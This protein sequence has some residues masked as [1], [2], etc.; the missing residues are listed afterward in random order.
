[1]KDG[2]KDSKM[3][4]A[5]DAF[6]S[7]ANASWTKILKIYFVS[8]FFLAT[9]VAF[10]FAYTA[11]RDNE[12]VRS[13]A[14]KLS[15]ERQVE[16]LR[17]M[18]VTPK[19]QEELYELVHL[20]NADRAFVF[21]LHNGKKNTSGLPFRYADM[22]YEEVNDAK[23]GFRVAMNFQDIPL[24]LYKYPHYLQRQKLFIGTVD[25]IST[26]DPEFANHIRDIGGEYLAMI[27]MSSKGLP[28]GFLCVS[29]HNRESVPSDSMIENKLREYDRLI[30]N[31]LDLSTYK[32]GE[33]TEVS[34]YGKDN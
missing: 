21:E 9:G 24:T 7:I 30:S 26:I 22:T 14:E 32:D 23:K 18:V 6:Q 29:Y 17:D 13:A 15:K 19:V 3:R 20:L 28:L 10:L 2:V 34:N 5:Q 11:V 25:E 16:S 1:M 8:F 12:I 4:F 27:Y 31:M 33:I